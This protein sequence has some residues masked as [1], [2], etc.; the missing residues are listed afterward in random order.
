MKGTSKSPLRVI[1]LFAGVGGFRGGLQGFDGD[2]VNEE[3]RYEVVWS[4]QFEPGTKR[5]HASEVYEARWGS[6][7]HH[8][9]DINEVLSDPTRWQSVLDAKADVLVGGFPCQ[10]YSVAKSSTAAA[11]IEGKK[12]V[13]WW[14]IHEML[15][16]LQSAGQPVKHLVLENVDRLLKSPS[17]HRGRDFAI[18]LA[19]L[20]ALGYAAEWRVVNAA[21]YGFAQRRKR[22]FIVAHHNST[23]VYKCLAASLENPAVDLP[24][25]YKLGV[26]SSALPCNAERSAGV[27]NLEGGVLGVQDAFS[28]K[29]GEPSP[30]KGTGLMLDGLVVTAECTAPEVMN[31]REFTGMDKPLTLGDVVGKTD[32]AGIPEDFF[33]DRGEIAKWQFLKGGKTAQRTSAS[34]HTYTYTEGAM[35]FPD[36]LERPGRTIITAEGG[37]AASRFKHVIEQSDGRLRRLVPDELDELNGFPRGFT[38]APG[39]SDTKRAFLMGNALV[40]GIVRR[41]G[42]ALDEARQAEF[43]SQGGDPLR[44]DYYF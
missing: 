38:A 30:F 18:I 32:P 9:V 7:N 24:A 29:E 17:K 34:G 14:S 44:D 12:G 26:L 4:N 23:S 21:D 42:S 37:S 6:A 41:I 35:S 19:S 15:T 13:L 28:R 10:D 36:S 43:A 8:N 27:F 22:V 20:N 25:P 16:R 31:L 5:Q 2:S 3:K 40:V 39:I 1:E 33:I 11:G